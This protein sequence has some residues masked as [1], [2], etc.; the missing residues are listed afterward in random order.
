MKKTGILALHLAASRGDV[1]IM[2]ILLTTNPTSGLVRDSEGR[3]ALI[4]AASSGHLAAVE[5][6]LAKCPGAIDLVDREYCTVL[7]HAFSAHHR[8]IV[9]ILLAAK[10]E[11][12]AATGFGGWNVLHHAVFRVTW[13]MRKR[14]LKSIQT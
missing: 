14:F 3:T 1:A 13:N 4:E 7:L 2:E 9:R 6:L 12:V 11:N 10:P 8:G 5:L